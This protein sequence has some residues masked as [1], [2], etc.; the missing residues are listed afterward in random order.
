[1]QEWLKLAILFLIIVF[2]Q[3]VETTTGF[4]STVIALSLGIALFPLKKLVVLLV[5]IA[6]GQ[7][8]WLVAR[9][10]KD[11]QWRILLGKIFPFTGLGLPLGMFFFK[12]FGGEELKIFLGIF[13]IMVSALELYRLLGKKKQ[14]KPLSTIK[15]ILVLFAGG[16]VHGMFATGGP[17]VVYFAS[18]EI[19]QKAEF[20]PT[21][22]MLWLSLNIILMSSFILSHRVGSWHLKSAGILFFA[23]LLGIILGEIIH[24]KISEYAFKVAVQFLLFL[25]GIFILLNV[26][27]NYYR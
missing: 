11:I 9:G 15:G 6:L 12:H 4:G 13:I 23:L 2:S 16:F 8:S 1:M 7:S 18:R 20:R 3:T 17:M 27:M 10:W 5:I 24:K 25:T 19:Q 26:I 14:I 21:I 22:S